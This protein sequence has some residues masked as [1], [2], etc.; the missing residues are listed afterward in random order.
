MQITEAISIIK[1]YAELN[2]MGDFLWALGEMRTQIEEDS[3]D[4]TPRETVAYRVFVNEAVKF[5]A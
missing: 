2:T 1:E 3:P 4:I 5:F